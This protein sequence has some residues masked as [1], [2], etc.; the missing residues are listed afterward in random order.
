M[1]QVP[2]LL[3]E[4]MPNLASSSVVYSHLM[5]VF[6]DPHASMEDYEKWIE[7]DPTLTA[8]LLR[9]AN[10]AFWGFGANVKSVREALL[11]LG[12]Q[13][14]RKVVL[15][16]T[17][18]N[19]FKGVFSEWVN[20]KDFWMHSLGTAI[21]ARCLAQE[22]RKINPEEAFAAGLMHDLG[23]L[24]FFM[25]D[26]SGVQQVFRRYNQQYQPLYEIEA[27]VLGFTHADLGGVLLNNWGLPV[28]LVQAVRYHHSPLAA[29]ANYADH[30]AI[31]HFADILAH[32]MELGGSG[33]TRLPQPQMKMWDRLG[34]PISSLEKILTQADKMY[35][36]S[37][38]IF[39][40]D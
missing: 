6:N 17:V 15:S 4:K 30:A 24:V 39:L 29:N 21:I 26:P 34:I 33:Q 1:P 10:S 36:E 11:R 2:E 32:A 8:K 38:T 22:S 12:L 40:T 35:Q 19:F 5:K 28:E 3:V 27:E 16:S 13:Q 9:L 31:V 20:M 23:R 18:M 25:Q 14:V 7:M 37:T